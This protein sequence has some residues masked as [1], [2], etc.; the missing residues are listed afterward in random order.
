MHPTAQQVLA[1]QVRG[2]ARACRMVDDR[3]DG[4]VELLKDLYSHTGNA[5][6]VG[7]TGN[8]GAGKS[9]LTD[10]LIAHWRSEKM[11]VGVVA[12]D[13]T[14]PFS[15]GAILGD[16]I[17]MQQHFED[18]EVF[19]RSLATRGA[20]GGLSRSAADVVRILDAWGADV[21]LVETVGV[22]QD[23]L[24]VTRAAHTTLIVVAPGLGDGVQAIKAGILEVA[25]VFAV[26][27]SDRDGADATVRDLELMIALGQ[28][29]S[30]STSS[31]HMGA[32]GMGT[33]AKGHTQEQWVPPITRCVATQN[34]GIAELVK[35]LTEHHV[36][37]RSTSQGAERIK[38]RL[39]EQMYN[40]MREA[41]IERA[42]RDFHDT[43]D[44]IVDEV[45]DR[46]TDPYAACERLVEAFA[47]GRA[48]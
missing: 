1:R 16:R 45:S 21:V 42:M 39:R 17:R 29:V 47:S 28:G 12:V 36:W 38:Q 27:K 3:S 20:L 14:S 5:W 48:K 8:P 22:G 41:L 13:P 9:T 30:T 15:G 26:N 33:K 40:E 37:L 31:S 32:M 34:L 43:I 11:R 7:V 19:I 44:E 23:E 4:H 6:I 46:K 24:E 35:K 18:P 25:D 10:R 2:V